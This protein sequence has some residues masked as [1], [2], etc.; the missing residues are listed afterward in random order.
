MF[1]KRNA[2]CNDLLCY[3]Q[4]VQYYGTFPVMSS[5][6]VSPSR[7]FLTTTTEREYLFL[8]VICTPQY[9]LDLYREI[10]T[11]T[12]QK[13]GSSVV[14]SNVGIVAPLIHA[15]FTSRWEFSLV[16]PT[17]I[18]ASDRSTDVS[19]CTQ[20]PSMIWRHACSDVI[21]ETWIATWSTSC[22]VMAY[23]SRAH[24]KPILMKLKSIISCKETSS[25]FKYTHLS[26]SSLCKM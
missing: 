5:S 15:V 25:Y 1:T 24:S 21:A 26:G 2:S 16:V 10:L 7:Y 14:I 22:T 9:Y 23:S 18:L 3:V 17:R 19:S 12:S 11:S 4:V 20:V 8:W 6:L 13:C